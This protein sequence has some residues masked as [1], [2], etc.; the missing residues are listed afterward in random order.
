MK[1]ETAEHLHMLL[2]VLKYVIFPASI[3]CVIFGAVMGENTLNSGWI[4][5]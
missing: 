4:K 3:C 5:I 2:S 1:Q